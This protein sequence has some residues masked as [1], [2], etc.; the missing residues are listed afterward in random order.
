MAALHAFDP[1]AVVAVLPSDHVVER[2]QRFREVLIAATA[3]AETAIFYYPWYGNPAYDGGYV[4]WQQNGHRP[5]HDIASSFYPARGAYSSSDRVILGAQMAEIRAAGIDQVIASW[6]GR[7]SAEDARRI[8]LDLTARD[9]VSAGSLVSLR[10]DRIPIVHPVT[11]ELLGELDEEV[12][13]AKVVE[14]CEKFS[15]AEIQGIAPGMQIKVRDRVVP[16]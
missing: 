2:P 3:A 12:A 7:G 11:G 9:G 10:R 14:V 5:P 13:T 8:V 4:H 1:E 6:W 15:V 16:R